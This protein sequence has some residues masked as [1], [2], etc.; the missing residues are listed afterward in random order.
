MFLDWR[1][2]YP[3]Y[4]S[5]NLFQVVDKVLSV[6]QDNEMEVGEAWDYYFN[7]RAPHMVNDY[8]EHSSFISFLRY[9]YSRPRDVL[10]AMQIMQA[11]VLE[12]N[13]TKKRSF[14][15]SDFTNNDYKNRFS[16]YLMGGIKD[17]LSFYYDEND[18][19]GFVAFFDFLKGKREFDYQ[20]YCLAYER[21]MD[22]VF[23]HLQEI[24]EFVDS[25]EIFLQ[26]LYDTNILCY[27]EDGDFDKFFRWCYRE[28]SLSNI[29]PKVKLHSRYKI[30]NAL[31]KALNV[32]GQDI[33]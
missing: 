4:R 9:S 22:Y 32:G 3:E 1:T 11:I 28:R 7:W 15:G 6:Q 20:E 18:Y 33:R 14:A 25:K 24:P 19:S 29:A 13:L 21:F 12:R 16:Q 26:F 30:H 31:E 23:E 8:G 2:T 17:Q 10:S 5:S 27:I